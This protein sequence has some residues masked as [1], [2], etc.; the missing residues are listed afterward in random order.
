MLF[1]IYCRDKADHLDLRKA[2]RAEHLPYLKSFADKMV[3]AGPLLAEDG[4]TPIGSLLVL[5]LEDRAAAEAFAAGDPYAN[6]GLFAETTITGVRQVLP[7][8]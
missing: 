8:A 2:T 3:F 4:E 5:D 6:V 1:A 7:A